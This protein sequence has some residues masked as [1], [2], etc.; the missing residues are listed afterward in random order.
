MDDAVGPLLGRSAG[1]SLILGGRSIA[2]A[3]P[4]AASTDAWSPRQGF[5]VR[6][7]VPHVLFLCLKWCVKKWVPCTG[8]YLG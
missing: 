6:A 1:V 5:D 7:S 8:P 2:N 4:V 3:L